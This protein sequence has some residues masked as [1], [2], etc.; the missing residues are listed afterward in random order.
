AERGRSA[1]ASEAV[2][3]GQ[4]RARRGTRGVAQ[5]C[6]VELRELAGATPGQAVELSTQPA[7]LIDLLAR[8]R[9]ELQEMHS[10]AMLGML[11]E[12]PRISLEAVRQA[13]GIV[14]TVD[15]DSERAAGEAAGEPLHKLI[16]RG[17]LGILRE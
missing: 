1:E 13:L 9:S 2:G 17:A 14:H 6:P 16:A 8:T 5:R 7:V 4:R 10:P 11:L 15:A 12:Q 3:T